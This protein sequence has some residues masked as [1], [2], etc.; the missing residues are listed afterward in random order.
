MRVAPHTAYRYHPLKQQERFPGVFRNG[1][2]PLKFKHGHV[3]PPDIPN[4]DLDTFRFAMLAS[5]ALPR[6]AC[7]MMWYRT[8]YMDTRYMSDV[9]AHLRVE[10]FADPEKSYPPNV[11]RPVLGAV[12]MAVLQPDENAKTRVQIRPLCPLQLVKMMTEGAQV[13]LHLDTPIV[14][15]GTVLD[16]VQVWNASRALAKMRAA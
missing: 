12:Q 10:K 13:A 1:V 4:A 8:L 6:D 2:C 3:Y 9:C 11:Y 15:V 14:H 7:V 16:M 5:K